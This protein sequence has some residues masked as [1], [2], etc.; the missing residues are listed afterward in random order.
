V[1]RRHSKHSAVAALDWP[2]IAVLGG[3]VIRIFDPADRQ[4][5]LA[6]RPVLTEIVN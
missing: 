2:P 4:S 6:G 5:S 3:G 1:R